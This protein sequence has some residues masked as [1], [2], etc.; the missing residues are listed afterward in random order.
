MLGLKLKCNLVKG[1]SVNPILRSS[2][3]FSTVLP[4]I[5]QLSPGLIHLQ[6]AFS[7]PNQLNLVRAAFELGQKEGEGWE[8]DG[9]LNNTAYRGRVF[10]ALSTIP[11][12]LREAN[13]EA[14]K[15]AC[16]A[17]SSLEC[18]E[19][20]HMILLKYLT[21]PET[22]KNG[23]IPW[24]R[25]NGQNDGQIP[26]PVV[27]LSLGDSCEFLICDDKPAISSGGSLANPKNLKHRVRFNSGDALVFGGPARLIYHAIYSL[28]PN[29]CPLELP[30]AGSR[31]NATFRYAPEI[32][33]REKDFETIAKD[34]PK[35]NLFYDI[36]K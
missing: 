5:V 6:N 14:L 26:F 25:D 27:S 1:I 33:G 32:L 17:D 2:S 23:Y 8:R 22:P 28:I 13:R 12:E 31:I 21:L 9:Q 18:V 30:L 16:D 24:H 36:S 34:L 3:T 19:A 4:K 10:K 7:I 20:T 11:K 29:T 35:K 15:L